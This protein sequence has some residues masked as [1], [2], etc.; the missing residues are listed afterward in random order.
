MVEPA[1]TDG[2]IT[3]SAQPFWPVFIPI[4][5]IGIRPHIQFRIIHTPLSSSGPALFITYPPD[6]G[7]G[8][9][10]NHSRRMLCLNLLT[11]FFIFIIDLR[12][13]RAG[14][15]STSIPA[16]S[17]IGS[18]KP[19][20]KERAIIADQLIHLRMKLL[21]VGRS[22]IIITISIPRGEINTEL[23]SVF[24]A[25]IRELAHHISFSLFPRRIFNRIFGCSGWPKAKPIMMLGGKDNPF[26]PCG[27]DGPYPL[28]A[29]QVGRIKR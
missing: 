4:G 2:N 22:T 13:N 20:L 19:I 17:S 12:I 29:I 27:L 6:I 9:P 15:V 7:N 28:L 18:V 1:R 16:I 5:T 8:S 26:Q 23:Q 14:L 21:H 11:G 24:A 25:S 10:E 3:F